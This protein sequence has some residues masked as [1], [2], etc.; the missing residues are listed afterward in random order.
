MSIMSAGR[1]FHG[2]GGASAERERVGYGRHAQFQ[3]GEP[4]VLG[5][6]DALLCGLGAMHDADADI[7]FA[8]DADHPDLLI[9]DRRACVLLDQGLDVGIADV[10]CDCASGPSLWRYPADCRRCGA[11]P[12]T[13][14]QDSRTRG[15]SHCRRVRRSGNVARHGHWRHR[16]IS[17]TA[18]EIAAVSH[19]MIFDYPHLA[20]F[21][22]L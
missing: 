22:T 7:V 18:I 12:D 15:L 17:R 3:P 11:G 19:L 6:A 1:K 2:A 16:S 4:A 5:T 10:G 14:R 9:A 21:S 20:L 8:I 13:C